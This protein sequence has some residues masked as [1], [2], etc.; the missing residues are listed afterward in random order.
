MKSIE[1]TSAINEPRLAA[2]SA[3]ADRLRSSVVPPLWRRRHFGLAVV[4][5]LV[6]VPLV[7]SLVMLVGQHWHASGDNA[8]ELLRIRDVGGRHTPLVGPWS[9][10]GWSHP[11]PL[12][13]W[14]LAP[15]Y[16]LLGQTGVLAGCLVFNL[17][18]LVGLVL[19]GYRR[20]GVRFAAMV[21]LMCVLLVHG[22]G[23]VTLSEPWNPW[24]GFF[25]FVLMLL[26]VWSVVC[27]DLAML[28]LA[29]ATGT[30]AVQ[31]HVG[32]LPL[33]CGLIGPAFAWSVAPYVRRQARRRDQRLRWVLIAVGIGVVLWLAPL[34]QQLF[35]KSGNL[36]LLL[37]Y[38]RHPTE[39]PAGWKAAFGT[40]GQEMRPVG[41]WIT[42]HDVNVFGFTIT[43]SVWQGVAT[44]VTVALSALFAWRCG[45]RDAA[46]LAVVVVAAT[47]LAT[48]ATS[49]ITGALAPYLV[50]WWWG[51]AAV[52]WLAI[53]WCL[54]G[55]LRRPRPRDAFTAAT[56]I[57]LVATV[58]VVLAGLPAPLPGGKTSIAVANLAPRTAAELDHHHRY[59]VRVVDSRGWG[60]IGPGMFL[61]LEE[62]GF[63]VFTEPVGTAVIQYGQWRTATVDDV[64]AVITVVNFADLDLGT[65]QVPTPAVQVASYDPLTPPERARARNLEASI[66][67]ALGPNSPP[68]PLT[69]DFAYFR[70]TY[71][72]QGASPQQLE[73]L[74]RLELRGD[75]FVVYVSPPR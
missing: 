74:Y 5:G 14:T 56:V 17:L 63:S 47:V 49:R 1:R 44:L 35:G 29:V 22:V 30:F 24:I 54:L 73:D 10:W 55:G 18:A 71:A 19:V 27:G 2:T 8:V 61:D 60:A 57:A 26:L 39:S 51:V 31:A 53:A 68:G 6:A 58:V 3:P 65:F 38:A 48:T 9:R 11:G 12:L 62:R 64:D 25:P 46:S 42:G 70:G 52:A 45:R 50:R 16:Q 4:L 37:S 13:F 34:A 20:G 59:L 15:F 67:A 72:A 23:P 75:G 69:L 33:V 28:P 40:F 43:S 41:P 32:Y 7:V 36:H 66:R 21:G